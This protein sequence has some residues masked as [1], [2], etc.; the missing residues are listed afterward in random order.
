MKDALG[1]LVD[2]YASPESP[3]SCY[4]QSKGSLRRASPVATAA[5]T[6]DSALLTFE[7]APYGTDRSGEILSLVQVDGDH[8]SVPGEMGIRLHRSSQS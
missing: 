1:V 2:K 5:A 7:R 4:G 8:L 3:S 6:F